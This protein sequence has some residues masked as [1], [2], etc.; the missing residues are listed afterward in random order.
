MDDKDTP[1][2]SVRTLFDAYDRD[3]NGVIDFP[4]FRALMA[5]LDADMSPDELATGFDVIDED[6]SGEISFEEFFRWWDS[7]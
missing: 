7:R 6:R 1:R 4:E 5:A 3:G 2:T